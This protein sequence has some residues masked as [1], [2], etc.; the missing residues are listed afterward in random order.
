MRPRFFEWK[1]KGKSAGKGYLPADVKRGENEK[2]RRKMKTQQL[3]LY[4]T[5]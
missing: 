2:K 5:I 3:Q 4:N 1:K